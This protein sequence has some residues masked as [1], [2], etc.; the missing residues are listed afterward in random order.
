MCKIVDLVMAKPLTVRVDI[1]VINTF[2]V[3]RPL[4]R[5]DDGF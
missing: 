5:Q 2:N 3:Q 1:E 4:E